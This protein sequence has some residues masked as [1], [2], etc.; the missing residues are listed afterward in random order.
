M[1]TWLGAAGSELK[2]LI[3]VV[4]WIC[5][6]IR[7]VDRPESGARLMVSSS[8]LSPHT[9]IRYDSIEPPN[10]VT[11]DGITSTSGALISAA[12]S[13]SRKAFAVDKTICWEKLFE[14]CIILED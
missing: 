6:A 12:I 2:I 1:E 7:T 4:D 11:P 13:L 5:K 3:S 8:E 10:K 9:A 14:T